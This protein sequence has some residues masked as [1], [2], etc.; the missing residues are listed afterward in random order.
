MASSLNGT[1]ITFSNATTLSSAPVT[2]IATGNGLSG[3]TITTTGTLAIAAPSANSV[4]SYC[5]GQ[6]L[7]VLSGTA[8]Y[9]FGNTYAAGAA[10]GQVSA[11]TII[12]IICGSFSPRPSN[13]LSGTWRYLGANTGSLNNSNLNVNSVFVRVA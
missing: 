12:Q 11:C 3:G 8:T 13:S 7:N 1:G 6:I 10:V 2:S 9:N 4:G 5:F